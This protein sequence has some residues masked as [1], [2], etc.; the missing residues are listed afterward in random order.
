MYVY[1]YIYMYMYICVCMYIYIYMYVY[2]YIFVYLYTHILIHHLPAMNGFPMG[3]PAPHGSPQIP[4]PVTCQRSTR[5]VAAR[6]SR[7][8]WDGCPASATWPRRILEHVGMCVCVR[9]YIYI[10]IDIHRYINIDI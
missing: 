2:I 9:V 3:I 4:Q 1:I 6:L 7:S 8:R 10:Y 5:V